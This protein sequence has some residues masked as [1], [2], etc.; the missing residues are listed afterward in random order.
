DFARFARARGAALVT[1]VDI[2]RSM[3]DEAA[4]LTDDPAIT[5]R[6]EA[7]EDYVADGQAFDLVVSSLALHY[8]ADYPAVLD[9]V[10]AALKPSG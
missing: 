5:Y 7:I 6:R 4:R 3:L 8:V 9:R 10:F 2:S 1:G